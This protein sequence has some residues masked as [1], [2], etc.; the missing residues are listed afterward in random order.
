MSEKCIIVNKCFTDEFSLPIIEGIADDY[1][2]VDE[3]KQEVIDRITKLAT[4]STRFSISIDS[5]I[6]YEFIENTNTNKN[7]AEV[8][9]VD[10]N[11]YVFRITRQTARKRN[12]KYLDTIIYHELC[13]ILQVDFL[14]STNILYFDSNKLCYDK[15]QEDI[16]NFMYE[17]DDGHTKL[18]YSFV[19]LVNA[20]LAVNPPVDR[21]FNANADISDT[22]LESTFNRDVGIV[23]N[24][25]FTDDFG[26]L[27]KEAPED[28]SLV[29]SK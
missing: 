18:W 16:V 22:L 9:P 19:K 28:I 23:Y 11:K 17:A 8:E 25:A 3:I 10:T 7:L 13:H 6:K 24:R 5:I 4:L 14:L 1:Y 12:E 27:V 26:L 2:T 21:F 29:C 15:A 20:A